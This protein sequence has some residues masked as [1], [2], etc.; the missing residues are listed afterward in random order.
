MTFTITQYYTAKNER[1]DFTSCEMS[2]S[3]L[4]N[5]RARFR[6]LLCLHGEDFVTV[7][8]HVDCM[9]GATDWIIGLPERITGASLR[10]LERVLCEF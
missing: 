3:S 5:I 8:P 2:E 6:G 4:R 9:G 7:K 1:N 10:R